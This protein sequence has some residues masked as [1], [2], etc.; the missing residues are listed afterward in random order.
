MGT[1]SK[2]AGVAIII[3]L[4][5]SKIVMQRTKKRGRGQVCCSV[6]L[7]RHIDWQILK[8]VSED[9]FASI[10]RVLKEE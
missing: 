1:T 8:D 2:C 9:L 7:Q 6:L 10:L 4:P 3:L 5:R